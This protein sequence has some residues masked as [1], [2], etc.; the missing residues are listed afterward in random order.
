L[1]I[2]SVEISSL[3]QYQNSNNDPKSLINFINELARNYQAYNL[4]IFFVKT[5]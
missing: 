2:I 1:L 5:V 3:I 4:S